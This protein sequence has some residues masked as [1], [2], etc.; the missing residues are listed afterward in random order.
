MKAIIIYN[1]VINFAHICNARNFIIKYLVFLVN[2]V[3]KIYIAILF[4]SSMYISKH[5]HVL[6]LNKINLTK[7]NKYFIISNL[8]LN[9]LKSSK[10]VLFLIFYIKIFEC[11]TRNIFLKQ[12]P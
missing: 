4:S 12:H 1:F 10:S 7:P 3:L 11:Q 5:Y 2:S 8:Y 6:Y 9:F